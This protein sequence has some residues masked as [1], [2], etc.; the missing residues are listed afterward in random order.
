MLDNQKTG[1]KSPNEFCLY[2]ETIKQEQD[3]D[4][5]IE[6]I[7]WYSEHESDL[8]MDQLAKYLNKKLKD[9]IA[10][11]ARTMNMLKDNEPLVNLF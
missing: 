9:C 1:F 6:T 11:E 3:F 8:E 7:V 10:Y 2:L 5:Y 4:S